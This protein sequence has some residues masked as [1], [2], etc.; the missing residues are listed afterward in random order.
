MLVI[1]P[2][3]NGQPISFA[4]AIAEIQ[5]F[6]IAIAPEPLVERCRSEDRPPPDRGRAAEP[7]DEGRFGHGTDHDLE[8]RGKHRTGL[9]AIKSEGG[10]ERKPL[11]PGR[12]D[13]GVIS[14]VELGS[15]DLR[16]GRL[17]EI[18]HPGHRPGRQHGVIVQKPDEID[19][20]SDQGDAAVA[21]AGRGR[22]KTAG[23]AHRQNGQSGPVEN[24]GHAGRASVDDDDL[25][26]PALLAGQAEEQ[27]LELR[28]AVLGGHNQGDFMTC[29]AHAFPEKW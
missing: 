19:V 12:K 10:H 20:R 29:G 21:L 1:R 27:A 5:I 28:R 7:A 18:H 14:H 23:I 8:A 22:R 11:E 15:A 17:P 2:G 3:D 4:D 25:V 6:E 26:R 13:R 16:P 24:G 9:S